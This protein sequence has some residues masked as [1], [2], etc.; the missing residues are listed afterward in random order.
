[1]ASKTSAD[2]M[3][4]PQSGQPPYRFRTIWALVLLAVNLLVAAIYFHVLDI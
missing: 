1:M 3:P 2:K 4:V